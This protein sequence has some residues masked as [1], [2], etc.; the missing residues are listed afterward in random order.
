MARLKIT[1]GADT[2]GDDNTGYLIN[3]DDWGGNGLEQVDPL[4]FAGFVSR[5]MMGNTQGDFVFTVRHSHAN[6]DAAAT[7][8]KAEYAR[9]GGKDST[10]VTFPAGGTL[11]MANAT[12]RAVELVKWVGIRLEIR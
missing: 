4:A 12:M 7:Y 10:V 8:W 2:L 6:W 11:T 1:Y 9:I 5:K 3:V